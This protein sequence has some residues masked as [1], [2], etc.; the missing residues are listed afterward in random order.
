MN[1]VSELSMPLWAPVDL[2]TEIADKV[3]QL[4]DTLSERGWVMGTAESCTGGGIAY[5]ITARPGSSLWFCGGVVSYTNLLK[6]QLLDV[7][8]ASLAAHGAVSE[9]VV[10]EM[11]Q[12]AVTRL[13]CQLAVAVSGV[14][15]PGG[16]SD[17]KPVGMVCFGW[18]LHVPDAGLSVAS[19]ETQCFAGGRE[20]V[21][22]QTIAYALSGCLRLLRG[23]HPA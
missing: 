14:A 19:T 23:S 7:S 22:M 20:Q 17:S 5:A 13:G 6:I 10:R 9:T 11:A 3:A 12:G 8:A 1:G 2:Q 18:A 16:G 21:R 15:G 4:A